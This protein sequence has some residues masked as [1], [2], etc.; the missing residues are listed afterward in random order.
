MSECYRSPWPAHIPSKLP[1]N[2]LICIS[3][4]KN[5][6]DVSSCVCVCVPKIHIKIGKKVESQSWHR[7]GDVFQGSECVWSP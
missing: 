2:I 4:A 1:S 7:Y 3:P 5:L 6:Q